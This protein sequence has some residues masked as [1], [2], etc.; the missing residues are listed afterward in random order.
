MSEVS[1]YHIMFV[2]TGNTCRSPM[3]E[4]AF[5]RMLSDAGVENVVVSSSGV[6]A[7]VGFPASRFAHEAA[8]IRQGDLT[9]H[10]AQQVTRDLIDEQDLILTMTA[11]HY[12]SVLSL[13]P[14]AFDKTYLLKGFP[15][16]GESGEGVSDPIGLSL[17]I[18]N[19]I[20]LDIVTELERIMPQ[21]VRLAS[22][23]RTGG[24][25]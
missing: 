7:V 22:A 4:A 9:D 16:S 1:P 12:N 18:Y 13:A 10:T 8:L 23:K 21:V 15:E 5:R 3:A 19:E 14:S 20:Y 11:A 6:G 25:H 24:D 2:C 17:N